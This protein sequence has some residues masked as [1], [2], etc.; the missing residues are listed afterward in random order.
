[1][2]TFD[3]PKGEQEPYTGGD[4]VEPGLC[5][6]RKEVWLS[7]KVSSRISAGKSQPEKQQ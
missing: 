3:W 4:I 1:M 5:Q 2:Y 7:S 6:L